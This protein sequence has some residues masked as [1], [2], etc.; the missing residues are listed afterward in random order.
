MKDV[1]SGKPVVLLDTNFLIAPLELKVD[2]FSQLRDLFDGHVDLVV[3]GAIEH[4][5]EALA[6]G[7]AKHGGSSDK[8]KA[9]QTVLDRLVPL[10]LTLVEDEETLTRKPDDALLLYAKRTGAGIA[11]NDRDLRYKAKHVGLTVYAL[12]GQRRV[13]Q[14]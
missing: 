5:L 13:V 8:A 3:L 9:A 10:G 11:S 4:E 6:T 14:A 1:P 7:K 2:V 12:Q